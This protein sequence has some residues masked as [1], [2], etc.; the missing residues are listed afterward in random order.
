MDTEPSFLL[1]IRRWFHRVSRAPEDY[2]MTMLAYPNYV[3][4]G[5]P[6]DYPNYVFFLSGDSAEFPSGPRSD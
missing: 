2:S 1:W 5:V 4:Q 6:T 3:T